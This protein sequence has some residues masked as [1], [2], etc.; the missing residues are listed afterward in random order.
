MIVE[1][2]DGLAKAGQSGQN[3]AEAAVK[4]RVTSTASNRSIKITSIICHWWRYERRRE[5]T[6][7]IWP[8]A[9]PIASTLPARSLPV[10]VLLV[11]DSLLLFTFNYQGRARRPPDL[12]M[13]MNGVPPSGGLLPYIVCTFV[14]YSVCSYPTKRTSTS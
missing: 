1:V 9:P 10:P 13:G 11:C 8:D 14:L 4:A 6:F 5:S 7:V 2:L 12:S 3:E